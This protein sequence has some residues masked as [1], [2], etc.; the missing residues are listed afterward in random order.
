[1]EVIHRYKGFY[2]FSLQHEQ[3]TFLEVLLQDLTEAQLAHHKHHYQL[4]K[5]HPPSTLVRLAKIYKE[6]CNLHLLY[7]YLPFSLEHYLRNNHRS[8]KLIYSQLVY[9]V[10]KIVETLVSMQIK[11]DI[12]IQ[13]LVV[14]DL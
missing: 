4:L 2:P 9:S 13:N 11:T 7:E 3:R 8:P 6:D 1:M 14:A 12:F 5:D 10:A